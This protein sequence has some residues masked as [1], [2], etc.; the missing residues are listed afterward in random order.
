MHTHKPGMKR[1][2]AALTNSQTCQLPKCTSTV[3]RQRYS[4]FFTH[5]PNQ[6]WEWA[7]YSER[8]YLEWVSESQVRRKE[9]RHCRI[10]VIQARESVGVL[11]QDAVARRGPTGCSC[12][13]I[14]EH[15]MLNLQNLLDSNPL[16]PTFL[17]CMLYL[18]KQDNALLSKTSLVMSL[19]LSNL[20]FLLLVT[21]SLLPLCTCAQAGSLSLMAY[22]SPSIVMISSHT[23]PVIHPLLDAFANL[24]PSYWSSP[25]LLLLGS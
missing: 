4:V 21:P 14:S 1:V 24:H 19:Y 10:P 13:L 18:E 16:R 5:R 25:L 3:H 7:S 22:V 20:I 6:Q 15:C 23:K 8:Q 9:D 12:F 2:M 17:A 11:F